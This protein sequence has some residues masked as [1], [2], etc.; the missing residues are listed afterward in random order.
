V[1]IEIVILR[2]RFWKREL[3]KRDKTNR[4]GILT[5]ELSKGADAILDLNAILDLDASLDLN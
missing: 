2:C 4:E 3:G 5:L 1:R